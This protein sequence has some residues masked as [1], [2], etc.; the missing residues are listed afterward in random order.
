MSKCSLLLIIRGLWEENAIDVHTIM[1]LPDINYCAVNCSMRSIGTAGLFSLG[2]RGL[3]PFVP[4]GP[5]GCR[6]TVTLGPPLATSSIFIVFNLDIK[7][8]GLWDVLKQEWI[9]EHQT[10][11][12]SNIPEFSNTASGMLPCA[13]ICYN[14]KFHF[15]SNL[16][17][18]SSF[19]FRHVKK[20]FLAFFLL[21]GQKSKLS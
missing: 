3:K 17:N 2:P 8:S 9:Q 21:K 14:N 16:E 4:S 15:I 13:L 11:H 1:Y 12:V 10:Y 20:Q 5:F 18:F 7:R 19:N 6:I